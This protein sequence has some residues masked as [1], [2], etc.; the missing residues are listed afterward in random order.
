M[1]NYLYVGMLF[2]LYCILGGYI[3]FISEM[4]SGLKFFL[5][6]ILIF[7]VAPLKKMMKKRK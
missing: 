2:L 3:W 5:F 7:S 1:Q 6:I 4:N